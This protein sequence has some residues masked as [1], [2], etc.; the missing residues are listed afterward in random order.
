MHAF[1]TYSDDFPLDS[2]PP[3]QLSLASLKHALEIVSIYI[4]SVCVQNVV[5]GNLS[6]EHCARFFDGCWRL[7]GVPLISK[8]RIYACRRPY[9]C[10]GSMLDPTHSAGVCAYEDAAASRPVYRGLPVC[11][12]KKTWFYCTPTRYT[13]R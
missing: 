2:L 9:I 13:G 6:P 3:I 8:V 5:H 11:L 12:V 10:T 7:E 4:F 1:T